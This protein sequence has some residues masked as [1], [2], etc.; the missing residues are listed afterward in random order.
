MKGQR[1]S[2]EQRL[3]QLKEEL[4][5]GQKK[6]STLNGKSLPAALLE[7]DVALDDLK[8]EI[9]KMQS[10]EIIYNNFINMAKKTKCCPLCDRDL[11]GKV[12]PFV[13]KLQETLEKVPDGL[14]DCNQHL[15]KKRK[16]KKSV[17][18]AQTRPRC[19]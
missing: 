17:I 18:A 1:E 13:S 7:L 16:N 10:A 2:S 8:K 11:D 6:L 14:T 19:C 15:T 4:K 3:H 5:N 12:E 9:T